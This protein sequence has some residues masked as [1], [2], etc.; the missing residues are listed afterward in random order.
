[1]APRLRVL[2]FRAPPPVIC[3]VLVCVSASGV[4]SISSP[5]CQSFDFP[6]VRLV[7]ETGGQSP[8]VCS[9]VLPVC[10]SARL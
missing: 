6:P 8:E 7:I 5:A 10:K 3:C 2:V 1:M 9:A 4:A